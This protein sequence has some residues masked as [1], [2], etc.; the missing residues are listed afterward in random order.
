MKLLV[1]RAFFPDF[2]GWDCETIG[3]FVLEECETIGIFFLEP[4]P[5]KLLEFFFLRAAPVKL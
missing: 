4:E 1:F 2:V 5:V 3:F